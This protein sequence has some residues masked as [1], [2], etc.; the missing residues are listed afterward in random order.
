ME[1]NLYILKRK[2]K[3]C[4]GVHSHGSSKVTGVGNTS[5]GGI[6][7]AWEN[8]AVRKR[9]CLSTHNHINSIQDPHICYAGISALRK[10][11]SYT[12]GTCIWTTGASKSLGCPTLIWKQLMNP[13]LLLWEESGQNRSAMYVSWQPSQ[14]NAFPHPIPTQPTYH[15]C[16]TQ[17]IHIS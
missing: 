15:F 8:S 6:N 13:S 9:T 16:R 3:L 17:R 5:N 4:I 1:S 14:R 2:F 12:L 11:W 10:I 7:L